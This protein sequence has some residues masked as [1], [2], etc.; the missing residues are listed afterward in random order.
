M[1][2]APVTTDGR[3]ATMSPGRMVHH[4]H[5]EFKTMSRY[6]ELLAEKE[7]LEK[8]IAEAR[9]QEAA[10]ALEKVRATV[11]EFAF[12]PEDVFG[13]PRKKTRRAAAAKYLNPETGDTWSGRGRAPAWLKDQDRERFRIT[14]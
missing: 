7:Q 11:A 6:R 1:R 9:G 8:L 2:L 14:E 4:A 12:T 5:Q 10:S 13:N 3:L